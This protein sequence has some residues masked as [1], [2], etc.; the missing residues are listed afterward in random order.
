MRK[1]VFKNDIIFRSIILL[2]VGL[3][4]AGKTSILNCISGGIIHMCI[5]LKKLFTFADNYN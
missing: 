2:I 1:Y 3:D 4:N 5:L